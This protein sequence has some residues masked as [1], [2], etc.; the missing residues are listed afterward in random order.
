[1]SLLGK[2][3]IPISVEEGHFIFAS[4][5]HASKK[6]EFDNISK[7]KVLINLTSKKL[8]RRIAQDFPNVQTIV[9]V[10]NGANVLANPVSKELSKLL[11]RKIQP[12][13]TSKDSRKNFN[14]SAKLKSGT[15]CVIVDD[16]F[17]HG[18]NTTKIQKILQSEEAQVIGVAVVFNRNKK[19]QPKLLS[20]INYE[21]KDWPAEECSCL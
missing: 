7:H 15:K 16:V 5:N 13:Q 21:L 17:N 4:G 3:L 18:T 2:L 8:A 1:M 9:T 6:I 14:L 12:I 11:K 10:A 19:D 20:L